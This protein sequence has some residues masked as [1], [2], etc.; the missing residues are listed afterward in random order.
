MPEPKIVPPDVFPNLIDAWVRAAKETG[1][2]PE[3]LCE[4]LIRAMYRH[5]HPSAANKRPDRR[6]RRGARQR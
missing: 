2:K 3:A 4:A 5:Y 6:L 1:V